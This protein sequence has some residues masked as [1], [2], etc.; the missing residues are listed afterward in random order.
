[1]GKI[2]DKLIELNR[3]LVHVTEFNNLESILENGLLSLD[4]LENQNMEVKYSSSQDSRDIDK[5]W[6]LSKYVRLAYTPFY[7]MI[8]ARIG[9]Y[10]TL[11]NPIILLISAEVLKFTGIKF[12]NKN[13]IC[14]DAILYDEDEIFDTLDF[15][16]I[17]L[18]RDT[19]NYNLEEYKNARQS[20]ILIPQKIDIQYFNKIIIQ[21][22][23]QYKS[24]NVY[25]I[26]IM[27]Y[28]IINWLS[29]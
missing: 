11:K 18:P 25:N 15:E 24:L 26:N 8:S 7:D 29:I 2:Y 14:N 9:Y 1:M 10:K 20:E 19:D 6:G 12:T 17:Y 4:E 27:E 16:K 13:A 3:G 21:T 22:G 28:D 5:H 23:I